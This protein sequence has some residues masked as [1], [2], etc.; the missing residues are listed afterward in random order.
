MANPLYQCG[1]RRDRRIVMPFE[2][3]VASSAHIEIIKEIWLRSANS[4][5]LDVP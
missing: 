3:Q 5:P 2:L 4:I 1:G